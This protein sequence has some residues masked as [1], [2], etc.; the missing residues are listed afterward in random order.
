MA[1][2][3]LLLNES[4]VF[5]VKLRCRFVW[6]TFSVHSYINI[7]KNDIISNLNIYIESAVINSKKVN[8][9]NIFR[10]NATYVMQIQAAETLSLPQLP[11]FLLLQIIYNLIQLQNISLY[12]YIFGRVRNLNKFYTFQYFLAR[13]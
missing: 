11:I 10:N 13:N 9:K 2:N 6:K 4:P 7:C 12:T 3:F 8:I 1:V 5:C